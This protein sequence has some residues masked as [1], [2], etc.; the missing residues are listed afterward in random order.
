MHLSTARLLALAALLGCSTPATDARDAA[1]SDAGGGGVDAPGTDTG[2]GGGDQDA[3]VPPGPHVVDLS[4]GANE[5]CAV[6]VDG[7]IRCWGDNGERQLGAGST[8]ASSVQPLEVVGISDAVEVSVGVELACA[9]HV[10]GTV[11]C[12]GGGANGRLGDGTTDDH[13]TPIAVPGL[14]H[15]VAVEAGVYIA[16]ALRDDGSVWCWGRLGDTGNDL[17]GT[18]SPTAVAGLAG[19]ESLSLAP[20]G[21][22]GTSSTQSC[23]VRQDGTAYCWGAN[24]Y[25]QLGTGDQMDTRRPVDVMGLTGTSLLAAGGR[26]TCA[27]TTDGATHCWGFPGWVGDGNAS[28]DRFLPVVISTPVPFLA[29]DAGDGHT[30]AI[31]DDGGIYCW[32]DCGRGQCG[33]GTVLG[34]SYQRLVPTRVAGIDDA[35][36]VTTGASHSCATTARDVTYCWGDTGWGQLGSGTATTLERVNTP[37]PVVW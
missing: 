1:G 23:G 32:G 25:G 12:W 30:C 19:V 17:G 26:H 31:G 28:D 21:G 10:T 13:P 7:T 8:E 34:G 11:S 3:A 27:L 24:D 15:V 4:A 33:D 9:R 16:C 2:G 36:L 14:D 22:T 18:T 35:V 5:T 20:N 6:L 29:L 37:R